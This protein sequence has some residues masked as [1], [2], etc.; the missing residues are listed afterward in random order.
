[1]LDRKLQKVEQIEMEEK[2]STVPFQYKQDGLTCS[3]LK[4]W[5]KSD[6]KTVLDLE[7]PEESAAHRIL[8]LLWLRGRRA[9]SGAVCSGLQNCDKAKYQREGSARWGFCP[10]I[11]KRAWWAFKTMIHW[12]GL[13]KPLL[14]AC[15]TSPESSEPQQKSLKKKYPAR[16]FTD[17]YSD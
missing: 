10:F 4:E 9:L 3:V 11:T 6:F 12:W 13:H 14:E 2:N 17:F 15:L 5:N 7:P 16:W 1:M 8:I